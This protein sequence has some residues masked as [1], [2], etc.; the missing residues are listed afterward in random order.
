[1]FARIMFSTLAAASLASA[2]PA[3]AEDAAGPGREPH[4]SAATIADCRDANPCCDPAA[5]EAHPG[6]P[7]AAPERQRDD[8]AKSSFFGSTLS[9]LNTFGGA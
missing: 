6:A 8:G 7:A 4:A 2:R 3:L 1:M 5:M 9:E